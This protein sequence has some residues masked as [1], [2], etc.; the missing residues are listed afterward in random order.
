MRAVS[1]TAFGG[2]ASDQHDVIWP[3][4]ASGRQG[5]LQDETFPRELEAV[6]HSEE[7]VI[8]MGRRTDGYKRDCFES[9]P[10]RSETI[11]GL[12]GIRDWT[13]VVLMP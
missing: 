9:P 6:R 5:H 1:L 10:A 2:I 11:A 8:N 13:W 7:D 3:W 12:V 4:F